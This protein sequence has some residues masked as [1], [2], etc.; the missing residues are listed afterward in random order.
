MGRDGSPAHIEEKV[1]LDGLKE[2][3]L[4]AF[5]LKLIKRPILSV[6]NGR[7]L[8]IAKIMGDFNWAGKKELPPIG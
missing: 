6:G 2:Q 5:G 8:E 4:N 7:L 1:C 3:W